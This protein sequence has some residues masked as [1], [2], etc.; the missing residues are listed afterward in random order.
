MK[1]NQVN[2]LCLYRFIYRVSQT[3]CQVC[4]YNLYKSI[5]QGLR[6]TPN[7]NGFI[8]LKNEDIYI[9]IP[10]LKVCQNKSVSKVGRIVV[11]CCCYR[12]SIM[13]A[14]ALL[15]LRRRRR[16]HLFCFNIY[17]LHLPA[18]KIRSLS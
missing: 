6:G 2:Y 13:S 16:Q 3:P 10:C 18:H 15:R 17:Y 7:C 14:S 5:V 1:A 11:C 12:G 9:N 8:L 4:C